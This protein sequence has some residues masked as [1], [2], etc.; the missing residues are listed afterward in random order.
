MLC[1]CS[2]LC[3]TKLRRL[4]TSWRRQSSPPTDFSPT[5]NLQ[6]VSLGCQFPAHTSVRESPKHKQA[7]GGPWPV[8]PHESTSTIY[9][10]SRQLCPCRPHRPHAHGHTFSC[11]LR[12]YRPRLSPT[13][14]TPSM[15]SMSSTANYIFSRHLRPTSS[16]PTSD[17]LSPL[18]QPLE[19]LATSY[20]PNRRLPKLFRSLAA[21]HSCLELV[22]KFNTPDIPLCHLFH[23]RYSRF[24]SGLRPNSKLTFGLDNRPFPTPVPPPIG[25]LV[26]MELLLDACC[27][28]NHFPLFRLS[29]L[30]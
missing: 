6:S 16:M 13:S 21:R 27:S 12:P 14:S 1:N 20:I 7:V 8:S 4:K 22:V 2:I 29:A 24:G 17:C 25:A 9:L 15:P 28:S 18:A 26:G 3:R 19:F 10:F 30:Q 5:P 11:R 23:P